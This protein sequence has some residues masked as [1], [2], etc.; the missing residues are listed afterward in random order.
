MTIKPKPKPAV[1]QPKLVVSISEAAELL[2]VHP[3]TVCNWIKAGKLR[4]AKPAHRVLIRLDDIH[5]ML[6]AHPATLFC[7]RSQL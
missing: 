6:D 2:G 5:A 7:N 4:A 3:D 1:P